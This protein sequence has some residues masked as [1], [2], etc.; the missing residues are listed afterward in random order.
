VRDPGGDQEQVV[1]D[2]HRL[3]KERSDAARVVSL[4]AEND[5][6][7]TVAYQTEYAHEPE[8]EHVGVERESTA[9]KVVDLRRV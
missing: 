2:G 1:D 9:V 6:R 4:P 5:P 8:D 7:Q 3:Q